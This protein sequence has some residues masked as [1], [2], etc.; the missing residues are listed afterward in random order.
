NRNGRPH[1]SANT[2]GAKYRLAVRHHEKAPLVTIGLDQRRDW[3]CNA[4]LH[5]E[6]SELRPTDHAAAQPKVVLFNGNINVESTGSGICP[7]A[8]ATD[9]TREYTP[10]QSIKTDRDNGG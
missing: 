4:C 10:R 7:A 8:N 3:H 1:Q 9:P 5:A 2:D 6:C